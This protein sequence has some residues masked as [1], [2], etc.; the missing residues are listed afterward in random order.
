MP[1][2]AELTF[3]QFFKGSLRGREKAAMESR[4]TSSGRRPIPPLDDKS[5]GGAT[6]LPRG[7]AEAFKDVTF[8]DLTQA[9][10]MGETVEFAP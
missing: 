10:R 4:S 8:G 3:N 2:A 7:F 1:T 9:T 6:R 5:S